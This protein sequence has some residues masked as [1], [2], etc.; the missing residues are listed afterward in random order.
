MRGI[1]RSGRSGL[2]LAFP[3]SPTY[4]HFPT[5]PADS[6]TSERPASTASYPGD[7][8]GS[9]GPPSSAPFEISRQFGWL[10]LGMIDP[11]P[12]DHDP[13]GATPLHAQLRSFLG[14]HLTLKGPTLHTWT[15]LAQE[16]L[17]YWLQSPMEAASANTHPSAP[18]MAH[19]VARAWICRVRGSAAPF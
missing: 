13:L 15:F 16:F 11:K 17:S 5:M 18:M 9:N 19:T 4:K 6:S 14:F 2:S 3:H 10:S 8:H 1:K 7:G 12:D